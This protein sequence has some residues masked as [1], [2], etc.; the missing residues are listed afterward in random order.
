MF[1]LD[2]N[3]EWNHF[4][5]V[6]TSSDI[7]KKF[8]WVSR[9]IMHACVTCVST[10]QVLL[11]RR[12]CVVTIHAEHPQ[13]IYTKDRVKTL[14]YTY[15]WKHINNILN[16][17]QR[18]VHRTVLGSLS[19]TFTCKNAKIFTMYTETVS[20]ISHLLQLISVLLTFIAILHL[21]QFKVKDLICSCKNKVREILLNLSFFLQIIKTYVHWFQT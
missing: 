4:L 16:L 13:N 11:F 1:I 6:E 3:E 14:N 9:Y 2:R 19:K 21:F 17:S 15:T 12:L 20:L 7:L 8:K 5:R 10:L 18:L